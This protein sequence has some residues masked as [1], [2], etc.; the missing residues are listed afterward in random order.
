MIDKNQAKLVYRSSAKDYFIRIIFSLKNI[1][2]E[3][4]EGTACGDQMVLFYAGHHFQ[5]GFPHLAFAI[6][7]QLLLSREFR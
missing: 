6:V 5:N 3:A 2:I 4:L 1:F 7:G